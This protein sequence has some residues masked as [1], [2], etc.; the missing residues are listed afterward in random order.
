M[1]FFLKWNTSKVNEYHLYSSGCSLKRAKTGRG[2]SRQTVVKNVFGEPRAYPQATAHVS[3]PQTLYPG[4]C[5]FYTNGIF[6]LSPPLHF[7]V[8]TGVAQRACGNYVKA[9]R[10]PQ[11][12]SA[13][14]VRSVSDNVYRRTRRGPVHNCCCY[15]R[16]HPP[17]R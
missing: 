13:P 14:Y 8:R 12:T 16:R 5:G 1:G 7:C 6:N 4:L 15:V 10:P 11:Q 17:F 3:V 9:S 2:R